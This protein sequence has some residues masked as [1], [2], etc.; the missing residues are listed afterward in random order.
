MIILLDIQFVS[1]NLKKIK[2]NESD[3][4]LVLI[5]HCFCFLMYGQN[6]EQYFGKMVNENGMPL[7]YV[8]AVLLQ[9]I[10]SSLVDGAA[11][12]SLGYFSIHA[13]KGEY[14]LK[15]SFWGYQTQIIDVQNESITTQ[16]LPLQKKS[17]LTD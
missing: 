13:K 11:T 12:D 4:K 9:K 10:D 15:I 5:C 2:K 3:H 8:N 16:I 1:N 14:L 6:K 7:E 17:L